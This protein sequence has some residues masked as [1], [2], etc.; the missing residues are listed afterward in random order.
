MIETTAL[1][2]PGANEPFKVSKVLVDSNLQED[3][4]LVE[5]LVT[6]IC[7]TD[8]GVQK[9]GKF[10]GKFPRV[11]GHEGIQFT[12]STN[13]GAGIVKGI[14]SG[15][16]HVKSGDRVILSFA[17]CRDCPSCHASVPGVCH[18]FTKQN[19]GGGRRNGTPTMYIPH[20]VSQPEPIH[21]SFFGQSSFSRLTVVHGIC[22]IPVNEQFHSIPW[23]ILAPFGCGFQT[24]AGAIINVVN[25]PLQNLVVSPSLVSAQLDFQHYSLQKQ[26]VLS[27]H[28]S[29]LSI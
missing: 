24:G 9:L 12:S 29:L 20:D 15:I 16:T 2:L 27:I 23:E 28:R 21:A 14:G 8:M 5:I 6:G 1:L 3:D 18:D 4:V 13:I 17:Y 25:P 19:N 26:H 11:L 22:V 7:H 10:P